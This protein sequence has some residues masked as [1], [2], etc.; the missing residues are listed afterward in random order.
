MKLK[1]T[2]SQAP[3]AAL[4]EHLEARKSDWWS[5]NDCQGAEYLV[6]PENDII[7]TLDQKKKLRKTVGIWTR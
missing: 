1:Q 7:K 5:S 3:G 4:M 6:A 2:I